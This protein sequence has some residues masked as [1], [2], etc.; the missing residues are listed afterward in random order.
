MSI[1]RVLH[2][3][4][5]VLIFAEDVLVVFVENNRAAVFICTEVLSKFLAKELLF[6]LV[7]SSAQDC[8]I[9][10]SDARLNHRWIFRMIG[11]LEDCIYWI[12]Q[13]LVCDSMDIDMVL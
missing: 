2:V 11:L 4:L 1:G 10:I 7:E 5:K 3:G 8:S 12:E 9:K 13:V 6:A